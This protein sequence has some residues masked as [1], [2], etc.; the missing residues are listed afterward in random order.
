VLGWNGL[1]MPIKSVGSMVS[2]NSNISIFCQNDLSAG[3]NGEVTHYYC[4]GVN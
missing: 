1:Y 4:A 2:F 3:E